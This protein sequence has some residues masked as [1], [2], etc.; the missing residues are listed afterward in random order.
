MMT[1]IQEIMNNVDTK[2]HC[3]FNFD[4]DYGEMLHLN[5]LPKEKVQMITRISSCYST[6]PLGA[7]KCICQ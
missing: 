5:G 7:T 2:R 6:A 1:A 4:M 3:W